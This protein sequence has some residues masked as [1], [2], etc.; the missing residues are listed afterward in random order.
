MFN[1]FFPE[2]RAVYEIMLK[3][4]VQPDRPQMTIIRRMRIEC[5]ITKVTDTLR[6][7]NMLILTRTNFGSI[8]FPDDEDRH[9]PRNFGVLAIKL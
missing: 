2:N 5:W 7:C 9:G 1:T 6:I 8:Q 3:N 4:M